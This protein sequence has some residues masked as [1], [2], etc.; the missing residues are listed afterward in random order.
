MAIWYT[1]AGS[2][3]G[4]G[5]DNLNGTHLSF[6]I[7]PVNPD[8]GVHSGAHLHAL[9][10][11]IGGATEV[12]GAGDA[13]TDTGIWSSGNIDTGVSKV[14]F[15][16][17]GVAG[18]INN[19]V[20]AKVTFGSVSPTSDTSYLVDVDEKTNNPISYSQS[21]NICFFVKLPYNELLTYD[22]YVGGVGDLS[23]TE[24]AASGG[25]IT[26]TLLNSDTAETD[27]YWRYKFSGTITDYDADHSYD[28]V[29]I[30][31]RRAFMS[32]SID[33]LPGVGDPSF[34]THDHYVVWPPSTNLFPGYEYPSAY[35]WVYQVDDH[36]YNFFDTDSNSMLPYAHRIDISVNPLDDQ[37]FIDHEAGDVCSLGHE[38][39]LYIDTFDPVEQED[40]NGDSSFTVRSIEVPP[41]LG[42]VPGYQEICVTGTVGARYNIN[43]Y[44][45]ASTTVTTPAASDAYFSFSGIGHFQTTKPTT[46]NDFVIGSSGK[47]THTVLIPRSS[48]EARYE[49]YLEPLGATSLRSTVPSIAGD[50]QIS[51]TGVT[52]VTLTATAGTSANWDLSPAV[53]QSISRVTGNTRISS[54]QRYISTTGICQT[55]LSSGTKLILKRTIPSIRE[56]M[57]VMTPMNTNGIP[58]LTTVSRVD[59]NIITL[60]ASSTIA[61]DAE[62]KFIQPSTRIVPFALAIPAG[63]G[64]DSDYQDLSVQTGNDYKPGNAIGGTSSNIILTLNSNVSAATLLPIT[65]N[66]ERVRPNM[67]VQGKGLSSVSGKDY[68]TVTSINTTSSPQGINLSEAVTLTSGTKLIVS[69]DPEA[70]S[71]ETTQGVAVIHVQGDITTSHGSPAGSQEVGTISGYLDITNL[72]NSVTLP[73]YI[74]TVLKATEV[75]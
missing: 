70:T 17:N 53:T 26:R 73:V 3:S 20:N 54:S 63:T 4:T 29:R 30:L 38:I 19:T 22:F 21:R 59:R 69:E 39:T 50:K 14:Q 52:T 49:I 7:T 61:V 55:A 8:T 57:Y 18:D 41:N 9:N 23:F 65:E 31:A 25:T 15:T 45:T 68:I 40:D 32:T 47:N 75:S 67:V 71:N 62:V 64:S 27:G 13:A 10:F 36:T 2:T 42:S 33:P 72:N 43:L 48:T 56:G 35:A 34:S 5:G 51:Q 60:S 46:D 6:T 16:D 66:V 58:H 74:E 11:K 44:K 28:I 37:M 1:V 12:D 24:L